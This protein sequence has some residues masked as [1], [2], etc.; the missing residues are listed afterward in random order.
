MPWVSYLSAER[1]ASLP[2]LP[3]L[4]TERTADGGL[5]MS[6]TTERFDP[7]NVEHMR[8]SRQ[9]AQIMIAHGG[10]PGY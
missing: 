4:I 7:A 6:A 5:L 1:A 10:D 9:M 2:P 3:E 8:R